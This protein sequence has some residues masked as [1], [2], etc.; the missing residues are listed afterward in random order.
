MF[1]S[2]FL[3][4]IHSFFLNETFRGYKQQSCKRVLAVTLG[5][6]AH[7]VFMNR[8]TV[9]LLFA[10]S[11]RPL[12]S[13]SPE[14]NANILQRRIK[15]RSHQP[16]LK[17]KSRATWT[18]PRWPTVGCTAVRSETEQNGLWQRAAAF[19]VRRKIQPRNT[20]TSPIIGWC[21]DCPVKHS[22]RWNMS[23]LCLRLAAIFL[24]HM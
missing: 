2:C 5:C 13:G 16:N 14:Q 9:F 21:N 7:V 20:P 10:F 17:M 8:R 15:M 4:L 24:F 18:E 23:S 6:L 3:I 22:E 19:R 11:S 12:L 1:V